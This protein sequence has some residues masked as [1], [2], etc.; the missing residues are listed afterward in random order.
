M[1]HNFTIFGI[2]R[3]LLKMRKQNTVYIYST[4]IQKNLNYRDFGEMIH[5]K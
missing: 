3:K 4:I 2:F 5:Q 1:P